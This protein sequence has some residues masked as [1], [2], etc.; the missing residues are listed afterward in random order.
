MFWLIVLILIM[1]GLIFLCD[2]WLERIISIII[3]VV[4]TCLF[5]GWDLLDLWLAIV[6]QFTPILK[7]FKGE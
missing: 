3:L 6:D 1:L 5:K 4:V 7:L 2:S